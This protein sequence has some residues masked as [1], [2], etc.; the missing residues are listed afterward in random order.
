M[1]KPVI[2]FDLDG[3]IVKPD[4]ND[5][6]W[7]KV[8]PSLYARKYGITFK[9]AKNRVTKAYSGISERDVRWYRLDFWLERFQLDVDQ[10]E[11]LEK[12][13]DKVEVY[14]DVLPVLKELR[15]NFRMVISSGMS[16]EFIAVKL[17]K[18]SL[19][20][21][22]DQIFSAASLLEVVKTAKFY[23]SIC[24]ALNLKPGSLIHIGDHYQM[25]YLIPRRVGL[26]AYYLDRDHS[27][28]RVK[29]RV[30]DLV[31]FAQKMGVS[32]PAGSS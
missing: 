20:K 28:C 14:R 8:V 17:R 1:M 22:F 27:H 18:C 4:F 19:E 9:E 25:D 30:G 21:Y 13:T 7:L 32:I 12:Y 29:K 11:L 10:N 3:T 2:S 24:A 31:E 6:I 16:D 23:R 26:D 5:L 15:C